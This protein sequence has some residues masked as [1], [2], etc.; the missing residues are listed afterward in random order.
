[1]AKMKKRT[2][3][4]DF[5]NVPHGSG[6]SFH[7][8]P[9][10]YGVKVLS[11]EYGTSQNGNEQ[12]EWQFTGIEG[13]SKGKTFYY[14]TPLLE[15]TLWKLRNTLEA[16][17]IE[18]PDSAMEIELD[19]L[20]GLECRGF[21]EDDEYQNQIRSKLVK[22]ISGEEEEEERPAK[23]KSNGKTKVVKVSEDE[24]KDMS[25]DELESLVEKHDL[26]VDLSDYKILRKKVTA[27]IAALQENDLL[28][29]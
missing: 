25:E 22:V 21:V 9:G 17:G 14:Y 10:E 6:G 12:I 28:E 4:A 27:V 8:P 5:T 29:A 1:M 15:N 23:K 11:A 3:E 7:I 16:L 19:E 20:E 26:G 18:V 2:V 13:K 24:V